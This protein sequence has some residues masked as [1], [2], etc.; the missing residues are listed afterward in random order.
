V[1]AS[2]VHLRY[3][4]CTPLVIDA[5]HANGMDSMAWFRGPIGMH[6]DVTGKYL[7]VGNE[8]VIMYEMILETG[9][10]QLCVNRPN[11]LVEMFGGFSAQE[12]VEVI[13]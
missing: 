4:T 12:E 11:V 1:G 9:V 2:E 8:D 13:G 5:I 3:D 7:D 10:R 6:K